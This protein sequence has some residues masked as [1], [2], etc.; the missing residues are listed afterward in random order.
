M[1]DPATCSFSGT[2]T[3]VCGV[4]GPGRFPLNSE[5][6]SNQATT[7]MQMLCMFVTGHALYQA[8]LAVANK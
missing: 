4:G 7:T 5:G 1:H 6:E 3:P 2:G 8:N